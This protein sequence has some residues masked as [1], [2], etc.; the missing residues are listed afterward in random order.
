MPS[1]S[2]KQ[3]LCAAQNGETPLHTAGKEA[4]AALICNK[5]NIPIRKNLTSQVWPLSHE[6]LSLYNFILAAAQ[7]ASDLIAV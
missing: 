2:L 1:V 6:F 7:P 4:V 3:T 5:A